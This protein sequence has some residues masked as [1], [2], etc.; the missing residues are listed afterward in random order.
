MMKFWLFAFVCL[1]S[2]PSFAQ[3]SCSL[4]I[5]TNL[6][7][8]TDYGSEYP[9]VNIFKNARDWITHNHPDWSGGVPWDPW[10]T[11][12]TDLIPRDE[13]G[14][15][16]QVPFDLPQ[17]DTAQV[18]RTVWANTRQLPSGVYVLLYD[19]KGEIDFWGDAQILR[20]EEGRIEV[21]VTGGLDASGIMAMEILRS[22][23]F[24]HIRN[25]RFLLPGTETTY[26]EFPWTASWLEK[27]EPFQ[28]LRFMDWGA[29]NNSTL[30]K[31]NER[32]MEDDF[33]YTIK[34]VPYETMI[35][36]CNYKKA[37][38]WICVPHK[39]TEEYVRNLARLFRDE[40]DPSLLIYVEYSNEVWNWIFTQ[41]HY[42]L[43]SLDQNLEW[44][45]RLG[46]RIADVMEWWT[47]EFEGQEDRL[48]RVLGT[49]HGWFD[50]GDRIYRQIE[51]SGKDH[52]IDAISPAAY[53][54]IDADQLALLGA[55]ATASD[56]IEGAR[57]YSFNPAN[58][59]LQ[60]WNAHADLAQRK[61]KKLVFYEGGQHFT[62]QP[63]GTI[64]SYNPALMAA[65]ESPLMYHLYQDLFDTLARLSAEPSLLMHFSFI[66]PLWEDPNQGAFGNFGA[67]SSQFYE[68]PPY[69]NAP[70]YRAIADFINACT[71][72]VSTHQKEDDFSI[73]LF[74]NPA[75]D[76]IHLKSSFLPLVSAWRIRNSQG[77]IL[78]KGNHWS[79]PIFIQQWPAGCY[80]LELNLGDQS[81]EKVIIKIN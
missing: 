68:P 59:V 65:Q 26:Q 39:A 49:Q 10:S 41:A 56:V 73:V 36:I 80:F 55:Q 31:W 70:K 63:W 57:N 8:V 78:Q 52:L 18:V 15:P 53:L 64:Q 74:P 40:L 25:I 19:G 20:Q 7:G 28:Q 61:G 75:S 76:W 45:E 71:P 66:A 42:G 77:V 47:D 44:P 35:N 21:A 51:S 62:P 9:F 27:L 12:F 5:G 60:G 17:A 3:D 37:D 67:L 32:A 72:M 22:E 1:F 13:Q 4:R 69:E 79:G 14:Y 2:F 50:I 46:P 34:G 29:T 11:E 24:D 81:L 16:L 30:S 38:A 23:A 58:Y 48:I 54:S 33:T 6:A 43:D